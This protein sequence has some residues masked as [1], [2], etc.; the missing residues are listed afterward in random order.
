MKFKYL[1]IIA[2]LALFITTCKKDKQTMLSSH[3]L[4]GTWFLTKQNFHISVNGLSADTTYSG[5]SF[6]GNDYFQFNRDGTALLSESDFYTLTGKN[7]VTNRQGTPY[8]SI[9]HYKY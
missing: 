6:T 1:F 8:T 2:G 5:G 4:V 7:D 3:A 9:Q